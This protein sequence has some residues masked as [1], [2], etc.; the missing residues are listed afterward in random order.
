MIFI[1]H[2]A[3]SIQPEQLKIEEQNRSFTPKALSKYSTSIST[4]RST[5][6][7]DDIAIENIGEKNVEKVNV[8]SENIANGNIGNEDTKDKS[9][10]NEGIATRMALDATVLA[11]KKAL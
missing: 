9:N 1:R 5:V 8:G 7:N 4:M 2:D 11:G 10:G 6:E 3:P